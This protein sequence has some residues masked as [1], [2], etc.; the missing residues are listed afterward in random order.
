MG[1]KNWPAGRDAFAVV[2]GAGWCLLD[3]ASLHLAS[4]DL[5]IPMYGCT[6]FDTRSVL[7][8]VRDPDLMYHADLD[9]YSRVPCSRYRSRSRL[10]AL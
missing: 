8:F 1:P 9:L 5:P 4:R 7:N 6:K 10:G 2:A 3:S